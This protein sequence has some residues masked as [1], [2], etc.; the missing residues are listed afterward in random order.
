M[1]PTKPAG[2]IAPESGGGSLRRVA[3]NTLISL[4]GRLLNVA[5][6]PFFSIAAANSLGPTGFGRFTLGFSIAMFAQAIADAGM[7]LALSRE[8]A[9]SR[10]RAATLCG[11]AVLTN[12]LISVLTF[13]VVV[14][15][16]SFRAD[17]SAVASIWILASGVFF[18]ALSRMSEGLAAGFERFDLQVVPSIV[19]NVSLVAICVPLVIV[20]PERPNLF[21]AS[22]V[23]AWVISAVVSWRWTASRLNVVLEWPS[24]AEWRDTLRRSLPYLLLPLA[25][26]L[27]VRNDVWSLNWL[28]GPSPAGVY[29]AGYTMLEWSNT[30]P[31]LFASALLPTLSRLYTN[32]R[33]GFHLM[34]GRILR[35]VVGLAP[36]MAAG[37]MIVTAI[38]L[39]H[40][41][42]GFEQS[43]GLGLVLSMTAAPSTLNY[44]CGTALIVV[45]RPYR[46]LRAVTVGATLKVLLN[47]LLIP[48]FGPYAC[49]F[50]TTLVEWVVVGLQSMSL[51]RALAEDSVLAPW[52]AN[53]VGALLTTSGLYATWTWFGTAFGVIFVLI[54]GLLF[55]RSRS[56]K[57]ALRMLLPALT[58]R[59][60]RFAR[61]I[62]RFAGGDK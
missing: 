43:T 24:S 44:S 53:I 30:L 2:Q 14:F 16:V 60:P 56:A 19:R 57:A 39:P 3:K 26:I 18:L 59:A 15:V 23:L 12:A 11:T 55:L 29:Q 21:A 13:G 1:E 48:R 36:L 8:V 52:R 31:A 50:G 46:I 9:I 10:V 45:G 33:P 54:Y 4:V 61:L 28:L 41:R 42:Q 20:C 47:V 62:Q 7:S 6:A 22:V 34:L 25:T 17:R 35:V 58:G 5:I 32:D 38:V 37:T 51:A 27:Y 49:A 40:Y